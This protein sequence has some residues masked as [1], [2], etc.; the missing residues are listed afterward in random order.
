LRE[1]E[2]LG[3]RDRAIETEKERVRATPYSHVVTSHT[4]YSTIRTCRRGGLRRSGCINYYDKVIDY[5]DI[6]GC[7]RAASRRSSR[8]NNYDTVI[9]YYGIVINFYDRRAAS[10]R[11]DRTR[12]SSPRSPAK[13]LVPPQTNPLQGLVTCCRQ[14]VSQRESHREESHKESQR[15]SS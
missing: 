7:R 13:S 9:N 4:N 1:R 11:S 3:E 12:L 6:N 14:T 2:R 15:K 8:I 10:K 5:H